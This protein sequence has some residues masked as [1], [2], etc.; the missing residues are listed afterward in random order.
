MAE[1]GREWGERGSET[2]ESERG[3]RMTER[4]GGRNGPQVCELTQ[5]QLA[6][7]SR[8]QYVDLILQVTYTIYIPPVLMQSWGLRVLHFIQFLT[9]LLFSE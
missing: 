3:R 9:I 7:I 5:T 2:D 6:F 1:R 8:H 4:E